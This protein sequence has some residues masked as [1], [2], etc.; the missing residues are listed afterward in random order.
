MI[1]SNFSTDKI[2]NGEVV[3]LIQRGNTNRLMEELRRDP[4]HLNTFVY[5]GTSGFS[6]FGT[7]LHWSVIFDRPDFVRFLLGAGAEKSE[8][9]K[10]GDRDGVSVWS[11]YDGCTARE[12]VCATKDLQ[13]MDPIF[14]EI[15]NFPE[16]SEKKL[17]IEEKKTETTE[18]KPETSEKKS[19]ILEK[20]SEISEKKSETSEKKVGKIGKPTGK[21][22][23]MEGKGS[24]DGTT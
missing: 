1:P 8:K 20:K 4:R 17:E 22:G 18:K 13:H 24:G 5:D 15:V 12:I 10:Y 9:F 11:E 7:M 23:K 6:V 3:R 14:D 19:E 2:N 16:N 21:I